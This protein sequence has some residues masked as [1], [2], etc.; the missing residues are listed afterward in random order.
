MIGV[1]PPRPGRPGR[2]RRAPRR[3][4]RSGGAHRQPDRDREGLLPRSGHRRPEPDH[5]DIAAR[6]R[7]P[8]VAPQRAGRPRRSP[9]PPPRGGPT[10]LHG[11]VL[12]QPAGE[13]PHGRPR[14]GPVR[15]LARS[16]SRPLGRGCGRV[17]LD[18]G[19]PH[20]SGD[21][22]TPTAPP[23][24]ARARRLGRLAGDDRAVHAVGDRGP[25]R[26][27][28]PPLRGRGRGT[29]RRCRALTS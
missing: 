4:D 15:R 11:P 13:R 25:L 18:H 29:R 28:P 19:G 1:G 23:I 21:D 7:R 9:A 16:R 24:A 27:R 3:H 22:A 6:P 8:R 26:R 14:A 20:R 17:P 5:P 10:A 12:R 2:S